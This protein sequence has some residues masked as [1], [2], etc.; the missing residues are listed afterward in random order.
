MLPLIL[1]LSYKTGGWVLGTKTAVSRYSSGFDFQWIKSNFVQYL[2]GSVI[3]GIILSVALCSLTYLLLQ[4]FR[5]Q[6][7]A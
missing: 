3:F 1:Y 4:I 6:K 2:V 5:K 7:P